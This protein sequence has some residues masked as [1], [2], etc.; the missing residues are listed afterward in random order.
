MTIR[1]AILW[2]RQFAAPDVLEMAVDIRRIYNGATTRRRVNALVRLVQENAEIRTLDRD[3]TGLIVNG[4]VKR[5]EDI[6]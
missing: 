3:H 2:L 1:N 6:I 4:V 5:W